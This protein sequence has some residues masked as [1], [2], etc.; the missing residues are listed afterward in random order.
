MTSS[1]IYLRKR[2]LSIFLSLAWASCLLTGDRVS[3][4]ECTHIRSVDLLSDDIPLLSASASY[5]IKAVRKGNASVPRIKVEKLSS[6]KEDQNTSTRK[7]MFLKTMLPM[8]LQVNEAIMADREHLA[9]L[10]KRSYTQLTMSEKM[11]VARLAQKYKVSPHNM[12]GLLHRLDMVPPSLALGQ[13]VVESGWG[14][15][16]LAEKRKSPFGH[17]VTV[18]KSSATGAMKKTYK[19]KSFDSL[20]AAVEGYIHNINTHSAYASLRDKRGAMRKQGKTIDGFHL[21]NGL[22]KYSE[23]G[24]AYVRKVQN[25]IRQND[26]TSFDKALLNDKNSPEELRL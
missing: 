15:D 24:Q 8:I 14:M 17:R 20:Y 12:S 3:T 26:L 4:T 7:D 19:L 2:T 5:D 11:W 22:T 1:L 10:M 21:A 23:L 18:H 25:I 16:G 13:S 9:H 6:K